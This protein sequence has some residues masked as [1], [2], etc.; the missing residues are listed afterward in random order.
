LAKQKLIY[1]SAATMLLE[2]ELQIEQGRESQSKTNSWYSRFGKRSRKHRAER[3]YTRAA[4]YHFGHFCFK[5]SII[6]DEHL[7]LSN[8]A[9]ES[10][11]GPLYPVTEIIP[12]ILYKRIYG[13]YI[14][15]IIYIIVRVFIMEDLTTQHWPPIQK[16]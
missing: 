16:S 3:P 13:I 2:I 6:I 1:L 10:V 4:S 7:V 14:Y 5:H 11:H 9:N 12:M 8:Q 15:K